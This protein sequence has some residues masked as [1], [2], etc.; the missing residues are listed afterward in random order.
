MATMA[1]VNHNVD[2]QRLLEEMLESGAKPP[3]SAATEGLHFLLASPFRYKS[4]PPAGSRFRARFDPAVFYG[5]EDVPTACAEAG[6]WRWRFWMDSEGLA[7]I[8]KTLAMTLFEFHAKT[9]ALL[10]LTVLPLSEHRDVWTD[11]NDYRQT[12][13]LARTARA[14]GAEILRSESAR[15]G[16]QGRCLNILTPQVFRNNAEPYRHV[17]QTWQLHMNAPTGV[18]WQRELMRETLV[19]DFG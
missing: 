19:F 15:N 13:E 16:P 1:L 17:T 12:Q 7:G 6:Y 11:K 18:I 4:P 3:Q 5:A 10:D 2:D 14:N 9:D 8:N